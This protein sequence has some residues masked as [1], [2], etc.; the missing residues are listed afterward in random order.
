MPALRDVLAVL[1]ELYDPLWADDWDAVGTA[2][3]EGLGGV[4]GP[5]LLVDDVVDSRWSLIVAA[6]ELRRHGAHAVLPFALASVA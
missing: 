3:A 1:D 4:D 6:R 5:V 2:L